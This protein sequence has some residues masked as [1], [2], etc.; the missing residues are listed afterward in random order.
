MDA[1]RRRVQEG[2]RPG[3]KDRQETGRGSG[4]SSEQYAA[5]NSL[6]TEGI[7]D[8]SESLLSFAATSPGERPASS[9]GDCNSAESEIAKLFL[10]M[11]VVQDLVATGT[12][13]SSGCACG[14]ASG[15]SFSQSQPSL[16]Q[17]CTVPILLRFST[18]NGAPHFGQGSPMAMCGELKPQSGHRD[19]PQQTPAPPPP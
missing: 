17:E 6:R 13:D 9:I 5:R 12:G 14:S 4:G 15:T 1:C 10:Y 8:T 18:M 2:G 19:H 7:R 16:M 11:R 3:A